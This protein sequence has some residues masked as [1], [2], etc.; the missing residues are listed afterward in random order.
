[1]GLFDIL[2][3]MG[4]EF[5]TMAKDPEQRKAYTQQIFDQGMA[6]KGKHSG[7]Y[8]PDEVDMS[9]FANM[10][11]MQSLMGQGQQLIQPPPQPEFTR[12]GQGAPQMGQY[13]QGLMGRR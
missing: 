9:T 5:M 4:S 2:K 7:I 1:M 3:E 13:L 6:G 10:G 12:P 8:Q 11:Q